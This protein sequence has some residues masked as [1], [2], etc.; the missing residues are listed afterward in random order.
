MRSVFFDPGQMT[1]RLELERPVATPDGQGGAAVS[2]EA[3]AAL[4]ARV[5]PLGEVRE[6]RAG[7]DVFTLTHRI[8]LPFRSDLQAGM[9]LRKGSRIFAIGAWRDP[10]ETAR[11][12]V[13]LCEE[14][15]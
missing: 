8:W 13:C 9:R 15:G 2:Y 14:A 5:E 12:I 3:V 1:A 10:D 11:Y 4:W 7:A 6:E